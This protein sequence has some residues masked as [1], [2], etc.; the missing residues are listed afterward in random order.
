M[1]VTEDPYA[2]FVAVV[3]FAA[4]VIA[5]SG[6]LVRSLSLFRRF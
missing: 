2:A 4:S 5:A 3:F 6:W 1:T